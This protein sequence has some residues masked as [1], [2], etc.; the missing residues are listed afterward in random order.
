[1]S[2]KQMRT[3][4]KFDQPRETKYLENH[5]KSIPKRVTIFRCPVGHDLESIVDSLGKCHTFFI[6]FV[7]SS[8]LSFATLAVCLCRCVCCQFIDNFWCLTQYNININININDV[9]GWPTIDG[10]HW[11]PSLAS[12]RLNYFVQH[13]IE[14]YQ[15]TLLETWFDEFLNIYIDG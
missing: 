15:M 12:H 11:L 9:W 7:G 3:C 10:S 14:W 5:C 6:V 2:G 4:A 13:H 8:S 1:M